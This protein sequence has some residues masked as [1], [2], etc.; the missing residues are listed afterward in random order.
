MA[1]TSPWHWPFQPL[2]AR[3]VLL[4]LLLVVRD[5]GN[6]V[7]VGRP[8]RGARVSNF[9]AFPAWSVFL[10]LHLS[11]AALRVGWGLGSKTWSRLVHGW[12]AHYPLLHWGNR[13]V[14]GRHWLPG[15]GRLEGSSGSCQLS[16]EWQPTWW[17]LCM[18]R[19]LGW[20]TNTNKFSNTAD[21][22]CLNEALVS[23]KCLRCKW[24]VY[25]THCHLRVCRVPQ[26]T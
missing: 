14:W 10:L 23:T 17:G 25:K 15:G 22:Y 24:S 26:S 11:I 2:S 6:G 20:K 4:T 9:P 13:R 7:A 1:R 3:L 21:W 8:G 5:H 19:G 12:A 16:G 18:E